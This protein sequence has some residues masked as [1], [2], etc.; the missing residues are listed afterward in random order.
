MPVWK[1]ATRESVCACIVCNCAMQGE[2][3]ETVIAQSV[4]MR[5]RV[6]ASCSLAPSVAVCSSSAPPRTLLH[7]SCV[8][9]GELAFDRLL[10][11]DGT[12]EGQLISSGSLFVGSTGL[13]IG[14]VVGLKAVVCEGTIRGTVA[15]DKVML[16]PG[17]RLE[18]EARQLY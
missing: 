3:P 17:A 13:V 16:G 7:F 18:G 8:P 11:V 2:G 9:Q 15:A 12:F 4:R 10:R 1:A 5:V 14:P 6:K